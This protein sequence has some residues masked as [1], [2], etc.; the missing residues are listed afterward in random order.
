MTEQPLYRRVFKGPDGP[1]GSV[2]PHCVHDST[3]KS[4]Y[5]SDWRLRRIRLLVRQL[6]GS[7]SASEGRPAQPCSGFARSAGHQPGGGQPR[8]H[9]GMVIT[10]DPHATED[11]HPRR[12]TRPAAPDSTGAGGLNR[13][14]RASDVGTRDYDSSRAAEV[15]LVP[16][17]ERSGARLLRP[18]LIHGIQVSL[19]N[20]S[21]GYLAVTD[22]AFQDRV[23]R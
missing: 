1:N 4:I 5:S 9:L 23:L 17:R 13:R 6:P 12:R 14:G 19:I 11:L 15:S 8:A 20:P 16:R 22:M 18:E 3:A 10:A 2:C 21:L 7:R